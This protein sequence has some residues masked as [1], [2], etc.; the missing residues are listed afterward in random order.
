VTPSFCE[1]CGGVS[2]RGTVCRSYPECLPGTH[3]YF[4]HK[5]G[6]DPANL[7]AAVT[8]MCSV[9]ERIPVVPVAAW[10]TLVRRW[11]ESKRERGLRVDKAQILRCHEFWQ[12]G[13]ELSPGMIL[14]TSFAASAGVRAHNL[15]GWSADQIVEWWCE[16]RLNELGR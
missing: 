12:I 14:E 6:A 2:L 16:R 8:L 4:A 13:P 10:M 15:I 11:D 1:Q 5:F 7:E 9:V 3:V